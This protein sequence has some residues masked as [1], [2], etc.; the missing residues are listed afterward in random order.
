[1]SGPLI[2]ARDG[3]TTRARLNRPDKG[4]ALSPELVEALHAA[5]LAAAR[6]G[7]RLFVVEGEG[8]HLCTGFD[9]QGL[10]D[11]TDGDL[12]LRLVRIEAMLDA[13]W[14]APFVTLSV[15]TG[16]V[17]GAGADIFAVCDRR[18]VVEG[19]QFAFPGAAFG[20][21]LGT[22][23]LAE[24]VGAD[25]ARDI[26]RAGRVVPHTEAE[27][28]GLATHHLPADAVEAEIVA[29]GQAAARLDADTVA[30]I[31]RLTRRDEPDRDLAAL[32]R[33]A[34]RPGLKDRIVAYRVKTLAR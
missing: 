22:R 24:R 26:L 7:T 25:R 23:R 12:L 19:A 34:A 8:R 17:T 20:I 3:T 4:N 6:D 14:S 18:V 5:T 21:V 10:E 11:M 28:I 9:L 32:V 15:G 30:A 33:S 13:L 2:V 29:A 27:A 16:R 1:M 31:H